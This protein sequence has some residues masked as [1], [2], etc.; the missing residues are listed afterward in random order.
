MDEIYNEYSKAIYNF[1]LNLTNDSEIA[2]ELLQET[3]YSAVKNINKFKNESTIKT[4]LC[5]IA[6]NKYIDYYKRNKKRKEISFDEITGNIE[7]LTKTSC[8][9]D[10]IVKNDLFNMFKKIHNLDEKTKELIYLRLIT[11]FTFKE[12][13]EI[14]GETEEW[15]R[16]KFYRTKNKLKED[17][18]NEEEY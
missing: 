8:E 16:V 11:N 10:F 15:T 4:W 1:L 7:L 13:S 5:K 18:K 3:F 14:I 2:E 9:N 6:K 12:I 17:L